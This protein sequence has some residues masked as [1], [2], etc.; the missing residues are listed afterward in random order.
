MSKEITFVEEQSRL[1]KF[2]QTLSSSDIIPDT[3]KQKPANCLIAMEVARSLNLPFL[4]VVN[5]IDIIKGK[6]TYK[7]SFLASLVNKSGLFK[8]SI[9]VDFTGKGN[10]LVATAKAQRHD[11]SWCEMSVSMQT[12]IEEGWVKRNTKYQ[13]MPNLM[14]GYRA[15]TFFARMFCP[16]VALG[17]QTVEEVD[18][19]GI[20]DDKKPIVI[21]ETALSSEEI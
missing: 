9:R 19:I 8:S 15:I 13:T 4:T 11:D 10:D 6:P 20:K 14:L 7:A 18:D 12:A 5:N 17:L 3:Y 21:P 1:F 2:A 16:E